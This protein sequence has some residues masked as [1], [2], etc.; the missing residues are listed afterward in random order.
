MNNKF[1]YFGLFL[2]NNKDIEILQNAVPYEYQNYLSNGKIYLDHC[3]IVHHTQLNTELGKAI[4]DNCQEF[5]GYYY[6]ITILA[7]GKSDKAMAFAVS[8]DTPSCNKFPHITIATFNG[9]TPK[10]SNDITEWEFINPIEIKGQLRRI[11][12]K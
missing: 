12:Y 7:I 3:T 4:Y 9:G 1:N 5:Q 11:D 2:D 8:L 6:K 10:D